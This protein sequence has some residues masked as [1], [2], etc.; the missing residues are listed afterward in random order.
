[1]ESDSFERVADFLGCTYTGIARERQLPVQGWSSLDVK[2]LLLELAAADAN[3][4]IS[5]AAVGEREGRVYSEL[6]AERHFHFSHGIGRS[7]DIF[8]LQPKAVGSSL[9][10]RLTGHL[11]LHAVR[12]CGIQAAARCLPLPLATGMS[13]SLCL[14][15]L[16]R[17]RPAADLV[18][19]SRVDQK[20]CVKAARHAGE[21]QQALSIWTGEKK[22]T[23]W[24]FFL[25]SV[26]FLS[27]LFLPFCWLRLTSAEVVEAEKQRVLCVL[28]TTSS[29]APRQPD[30]LTELADICK[31]ADICHL[32]NNAYGLQCS[33]CCALVEQAS[34]RGRV[35]LVVSSSDKNFLTPVGGSLVYGPDPQLVAEVS[36]CYPGRANMSPILDLFITL[37]QMGQEGLQ[38]L[39]QERKRLFHM[40]KDELVKTCEK[41]GLRLLPSP[42]NRISIALDLS[43]LT[44]GLPEE[45]AA[46]TGRFSAGCGMIRSCRSPPV[47]RVS[48]FLT[49]RI[50]LFS[51]ASFLGS[52]LFIRRCSGLRVVVP[53]AAV[54]KVDGVSFCSFGSHCRYPVPYC[55]VAC[56]IGAEESELRL[57]LKRFCRVL[58]EIKKIPKPLNSPKANSGSSQHHQTPNADTEDPLPRNEGTKK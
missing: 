39:L 6:V 54:T 53:S 48:R 16:R 46:K 49:T 8:A 32:I 9:L 1:M 28:S 21:K 27:C 22:Q 40:F 44:E 5:Q 43:A 18:I 17:R 26:S 30:L 10:Y 31:K 7:G 24:G 4:Q 19:A 42:A 56:A 41:T 52:Q 2:Q 13:L 11:C 35:D 45:E 50:M 58:S 25:L 14:T 55:S 33:K 34:R 23:E 36:A 37:L 20:S 29:F 51:A 15:A 12:L 38:R 47:D 57:F 3:S